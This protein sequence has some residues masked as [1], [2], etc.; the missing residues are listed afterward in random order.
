[1]KRL[2]FILA[3]A[4][5]LPAVALA[6]SLPQ[7]A[8]VTS[9]ASYVA[10]LEEPG[11][12]FGG[13]SVGANVDAIIAV[14][15]AGY[16]PAKLVASDGATPSDYIKAN[17]AGATKA[18]DAA[19]VALGAMAVGLDPSDISGTNVV[20]AITAGLD[21]STGR[22]APD[23][24]SQS[25]AMLGLACTN[26][27]VAP[28]AVT[29]LE[30]AQVASDGGWGFQ[31]TSDPD[32]TAIAVQALIASGVPATDPSVAAAVAYFKANQLDD[33]GWGYP[34]ASNVNSTA[35]VVQA[36]I[37]AGQDPS[38]YVKSG[39]DPVSYLLS[40][41]QADGSFPG[42]S[43]AVATTQVLPA[44][45]GRTYCNAAS[46]TISHEGAPPVE[47]VTPTPTATTST[48]T[49][50]ASTTG[51][52]SASATAPTETPKPT[53]TASTP[54]APAPPNTGSGTGAGSDVWMFVVGA[55]ALFATASGAAAAA[56]R[57]ER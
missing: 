6:A 34:P 18:T 54:H 30:G 56:L 16:D 27:A 4:A 14:R 47:T 50:T 31:G 13:G 38:T 15:A 21:A 44:L 36:L 33:G 17:A 20:A 9:G 35:Y 39:V 11:G 24:F 53:R 8:A 37:A 10:S 28:V 7:P 19:K 22:F 52:P 55:L 45:A 48:A 46:T 5:L 26:N 23:D 41:Q 3:G 12:G 51:T 49:P 57:R 25:I 1:M 40:Q 43:V 42:F 2:L 32:T 29:A